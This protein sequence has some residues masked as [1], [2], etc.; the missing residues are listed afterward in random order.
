MYDEGGDDSVNALQDKL[1][2]M[3]GMEAALW[4]PSGTMANQ[5]CL[6][7]HLQQPPHSVL[8][9]Y[10]AHVHCWEGGGLAVFSQATSTC[11]HPRNGIHLTLEDVK[12]RIIADGNSEY[13]ALQGRCLF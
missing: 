7:T 8:V 6:R 9:D 3:T 1:V 13:H 2:G 10:R 5:I 11:A 4:T 12:K